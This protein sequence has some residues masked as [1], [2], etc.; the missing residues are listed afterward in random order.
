MTI[1]EAAQLVIQAAAMA[2]GGE[3]FILDM[4]EPVRI[5]DLA[6]KMIELSGMTVR[7]EGRP[8]GDIDI[9]VVG[10]RPGEKLYE[11]LLIGD[12]PTTTAHPLI[13]QAREHFLPLP[14]LE[15]LLARLESAIDTGDVP[16]ALAVL[17]AGVPEFVP[18]SDVV[19]WLAT[20][21]ASG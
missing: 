8:D 3:V 6:R 15:V 19:D 14:D 5:A 18:T 1:P 2:R 9:N 10:L 4:G 13:M 16:E 11:E 7:E 20:A 17:R 12:N 21:N